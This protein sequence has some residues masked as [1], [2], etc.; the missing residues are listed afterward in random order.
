MPLARGTAAC[1]Y[2]TILSL[3][4]AAGMPITV[5]I[6]KDYQVDWEAILEPHPDIFISALNRWLVPDAARPDASKGETLP[7]RCVTCRCSLNVDVDKGIQR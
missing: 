2:T 7:V 6:P 5:S 3:F 4:W 1:G